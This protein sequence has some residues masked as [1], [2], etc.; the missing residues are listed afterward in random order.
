MFSISSYSDERLG[1]FGWPQIV[2]LP[3]EAVDSFYVELSVF[4]LI[5]F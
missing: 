4:L 3:S 1:V 2:S 5:F